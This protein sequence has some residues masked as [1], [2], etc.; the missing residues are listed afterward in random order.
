MSQDKIDGKEFG[1]DLVLYEESAVEDH[2]R[3]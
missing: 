1:F 2:I 3:V